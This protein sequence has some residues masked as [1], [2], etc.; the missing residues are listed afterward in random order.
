VSLFNKGVVMTKLKIAKNWL[1]DVNQVG[2][3]AALYNVGGQFH[4]RM[5]DNELD[6]DEA[7]QCL[8]KAYKWYLRAAKTGCVS[9]QSQV[10]GFLK[11]GWASGEI[12]YFESVYWFKKAANSGCA[13]A[14]TQLSHSYMT[15]QGVEADDSRSAQFAKQAADLN[16]GPGYLTMGERYEWGRG[17]QIN[18]ETAKMYYELARDNKPGYPRLKITREHQPIIPWDYSKAIQQMLDRVN[19]NIA[20]GKK[21]KWGDQEVIFA[22]LEHWRREDEKAEQEQQK[23]NR[24]TNIQPIQN[25]SAGQAVDVETF[26]NQKLSEEN[27]ESELENINMEAVVLH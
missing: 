3:G 16:Y 2:L 15:G 20:I 18:F 7:T 5:L 27:K 19:Y 12:N 21:N 25:H 6:E 26:N 4:Q 13:F 14:M 1:I 24:M 10:G 9:A 17:V 8:S 11:Q 23:K 22:M